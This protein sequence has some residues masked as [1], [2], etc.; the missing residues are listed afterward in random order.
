MVLEYVPGGDMF[1]HLRKLGSFKYCQ[2]SRPV[3]FLVL[4]CSRLSNFHREPH[5][6]FYATQIVLAFEYLHHLGL[7][8]RDL[9]PENIMIDTAGYAKVLPTISFQS[10]PKT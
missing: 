5:A 10:K 4:H 2:I 8:Y 3:L 1:T 9:K 7:V 6:R